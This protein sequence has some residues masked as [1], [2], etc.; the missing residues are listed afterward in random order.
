MAT[1]GDKVKRRLVRPILEH[2]LGFGGG[3]QSFV[4][5]HVKGCEVNFLTRWWKTGLVQASMGRQI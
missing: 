1:S 4:H 3:Y 2:I 5:S